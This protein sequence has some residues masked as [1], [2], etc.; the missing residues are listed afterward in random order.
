[1]A[2]AIVVPNVNQEI[3]TYPPGV[4][5]FTSSCQKG[6]CCSIVGF[7]C[8][9]LWFIVC[10]FVFCFSFLLATALYVLLRFTNSD[11]SLVSSNISCSSL[12]NSPYVYSGS[13]EPL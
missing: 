5:A 1:M 13:L 7:P 4:P 2:A 10:P 3:P 12:T 9:V 8:D 11:Y 6:S